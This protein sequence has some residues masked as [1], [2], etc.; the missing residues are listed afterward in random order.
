MY[1]KLIIVTSVSDKYRNGLSLLGL[2][3]QTPDFA[4]GQFLC[5]SREN[6]IAKTDLLPE[7]DYR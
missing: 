5:K 1:H 6:D 3:F 4:G 7:R 2:R